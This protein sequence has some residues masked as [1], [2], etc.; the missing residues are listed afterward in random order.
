VTYDPPDPPPL[1]SIIVPTTLRNAVTRRCLQSVLSRTRYRDFELLLVAAE[2][3]L[4]AGRAAFADLIGDARVR[5]LGYEAAP[6]NYS[7]INN[8]GA[9]QARGSL[10]CFLNDDVEVMSEGWLAQL[11]ARVSLAGVGAAGPMLYY[12]SNLIQHAGIL[13]GVDGV[14]DHAFRNVERG[15][16]GYFARAALDQDYSCLTAACLLVRRE[17]FEAVGGF[18]LALPVAFNDVD[19]CLRMRRAGARLVWTPAAQMVHHESATLG[20]PDSAARSAQFER[21]IALMR[22]RWGPILD[23][24]PA[25]NPNLS[26]ER[27]HQ[28]QLAAP[29]RTAFASGAF[30]PGVAV[31][32][33]SRIA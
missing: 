9:A 20:A 16:I 33:T 14:A 6:F 2:P 26:L 8:L 32:R 29:P 1:V 25:Y 7:R 19:L 12:P 24:D 30:E 4:A 10:L 18:D 17:T 5:T 21:D 13:L 22:S 31:S 15:Q 28:F 11:V 23:N 3:D 27:E